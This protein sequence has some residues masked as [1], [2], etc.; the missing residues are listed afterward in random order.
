VGRALVKEVFQGR[1]TMGVDDDGVEGS[2]FNSR[3]YGVGVGGGEAWG[4]T[5]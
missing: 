3:H 4:E 5:T 2:G 1:G